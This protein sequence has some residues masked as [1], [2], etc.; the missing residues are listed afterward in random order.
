MTEYD[1]TDISGV[2]PARAEKLT[3]AGF[4]DVESVASADEED[5]DD[6]LSAG[7]DA[8]EIVA[9]A[10]ETLLDDDNDEA[11]EDDSSL[12]ADPREKTKTLTIDDAQ[13]A[14]YLYKGLIDDELRLRK[15]NK[16]DEADEVVELGDRLLADVGSD[17]GTIEVDLDDLSRLY[18]AVR[19]IEQEFQQTRGITHLVG[20][21]RNARTDIQELRSSLW[22]DS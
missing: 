11:D 3:N 15:Q 16:V 20:K 10:R 14:R 8:D 6:V 18:T 13:T 5:L 17:G 19:N 9:N 4:G 1:L 2:G 12:N 7:A 22:P 21:L